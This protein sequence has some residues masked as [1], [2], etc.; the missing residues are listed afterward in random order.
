MRLLRNALLFWHTLRYLRLEQILQRLKFRLMRPKLDLRPAPGV[1]S[2]IGTWQMAA[3]RQPSMR[4]VNRFLF[5]N[6]EY[7][8][9]ASEDWNQPSL[10]LLWLYNLH[11]FDDLNA[12]GSSDRIAW[13]RE[14]IDRWISENAPGI[15]VG[16]E[17]YPLSLR[18]INWIKWTLNGNE[19]KETAIQSLAVQ[20]RFLSQRLERHLLGNHLFTNAK[21]LIFAGCFFEGHEADSWLSLGMR[22]LSQEMHEQILADGGHFERSTMYHALAYE[23]MLDLLNLSQTF[24]AV[25]MPW[26]H[27]INSWPDTTTKMSKWLLAMAHPDGE[28][29]LFNDAAFDIAPS[30]GKLHAYA[31]RVLVNE[32]YTQPLPS[33]IH[34]KESGYVRLAYGPAVALLDVAPVGPD[35]LPGHAHADTLSFELSL[36][37]QRVLVNSG[38]SCYGVSAERLRQRGTSAHNTVVINGQDSSE[39]WSGFRVARRAY[40]FG[41][42]IEHSPEK[43]TT[44]LCCS[45]NGY[46]RLPGKPK[47]HRSWRMDA[48]GLKVTDRIDGPIKYNSVARFH[49]HPTA[50]VQI[51]LEKTEGI[52]TLPD[53]VVMSWRIDNGLAKIETST[54]HPRFGQSIPNVCLV[55]QLVDESLT[56]QFHW[57][58]C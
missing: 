41:L 8:I 40:P 3:A 29:G 6:A 19:L 16:W 1:R 37:V 42:N 7:E 13:H 27:H 35:Y 4:S 22:I 14:L 38:I 18:I 15:G 54:W 10:P 5:L 52:A 32:A 55:V 31:C 58:E 46:Q 47:H 12:E 11:Y 24:P 30:L 36:G 28:I 23:D 43:M 21:A 9:T 56:I 26:R 2:F 49:F 39:M 33:F 53:G 25:F 17:P 44:E 45:H 51:G 34:L 20:A 48:N 57:G 50:K